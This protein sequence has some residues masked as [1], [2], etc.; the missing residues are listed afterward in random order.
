MKGRR[1]GASNRE[2]NRG[3]V[4]REERVCREKGELE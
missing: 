1:D 4:R 3:K 2:R